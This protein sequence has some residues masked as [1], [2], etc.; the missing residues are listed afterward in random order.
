MV[1]QHGGGGHGAK[2]A[3]WLDRQQL[4]V[5]NTLFQAADASPAPTASQPRASTT[6]V[7]VVHRM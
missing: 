6:T 2:Y 1:G 7:R 4:L 3:D 5:W